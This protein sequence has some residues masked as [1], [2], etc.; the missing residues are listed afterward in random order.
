MIRSMSRAASALISASPSSVEASRWEVAASWSAPRISSTVNTPF[1][2]IASM[3]DSHIARAARPAAR[4]DKSFISTISR[5]P[6][7]GATR[8]RLCHRL[9]RRAPWPSFVDR[10]PMLACGRLGSGSRAP[11]RATGAPPRFPEIPRDSPFPA[12]GVLGRRLPRRGRSLEK[13]TTVWIE[14]QANHSW[15]DPHLHRLILVTTSA[16]AGSARFYGDR[17]H[18]GGRPRPSAR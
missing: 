6:S 13:P 10:R 4:S 18:I 3:S 16:P 8:C 12:A 9:D 2:A 17:R 7:H 1:S 15:N 5:T 11:L 14:G